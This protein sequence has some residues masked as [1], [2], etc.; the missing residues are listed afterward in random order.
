MGAI[1]WIL[2]ILFVLGAIYVGQ[3]P[4]II[5]ETPL[6][7]IFNKDN[8]TNIL[9]PLIINNTPFSTIT[10]ADNKIYYGKPWQYYSCINNNDC[11]ASFGSG[12]FCNQ[13]IG[14][15]YANN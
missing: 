8:N 15:C 11:R 2:L 4:D 7:N 3:N 9:E 6:T 12:T 14:E 1:L 10:Y 5:K 13:T